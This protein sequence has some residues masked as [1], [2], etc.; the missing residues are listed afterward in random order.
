MNYY[1]CDI[2]SYETFF[3][4]VNFAILK[5]QNPFENLFYYYGGER[6]KFICVR[7]VFSAV[8]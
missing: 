2:H 6:L 8:I 5:F 3:C 7:W 1:F 4:T